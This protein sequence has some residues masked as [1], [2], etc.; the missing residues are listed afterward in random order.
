[1]AR[2]SDA[3]KNEIHRRA[4]AGE[5]GSKLAEEYGTSASNISRIKNHFTPTNGGEE[6]SITET[7]DG[8][9]RQVGIMSAKHSGTLFT[10]PEDATFGDLMAAVKESNVKG[11]FKGAKGARKKLTKNSDKL[12][13]PGGTIYIYLLP[14]KTDAGC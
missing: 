7:T 10:V 9:T 14:T 8:P 3:Q 5:S 2:L 6:G 12:P 1:M 11:V 4:N 13:N